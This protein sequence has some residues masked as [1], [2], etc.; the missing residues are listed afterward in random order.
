MELKGKIMFTVTAELCSF[1]IISLRCNTEFPKLIF[2]CSPWLWGFASDV[3]SPASFQCL[4]W[5]SWVRD[6]STD[7]SCGQMSEH[8]RVLACMRAV[9]PSG[10][11]SKAKHIF[12]HQTVRKCPWKGT[13][14]LVGQI[15]PH[16]LFNQKTGVMNQGKSCWG[17]LKDINN[18]PGATKQVKKQ[19]NWPIHLR[20]LSL[21]KSSIYNKSGW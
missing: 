7:T 17:S 10:W 2:F 15:I 18:K 1:A 12:I 9:V 8:T 19:I 4:C 5:I 6:V 16:F 21:P 13:C 14:A 11:Q 20:P 3:F